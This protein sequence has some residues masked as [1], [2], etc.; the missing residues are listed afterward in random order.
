MTTMNVGSIGAQQLLQQIIHVEIICISHL[1]I[2]HS[3]HLC[4]LM[5]FPFAQSGG[6]CMDSSKLRQ[7]E[8]CDYWAATYA[9]SSYS[10]SY[11]GT[12]ED[13]RLGYNSSYQQR[14]FSVHPVANPKSW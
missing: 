7:N 10:W 14:G 1:V 4:Q 8:T 12:S 11:Y 9:S 13:N 5:V 6:L 2:V 3:T